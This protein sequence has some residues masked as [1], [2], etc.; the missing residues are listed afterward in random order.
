MFSRKQ[1][2]QPRNIDLNEVIANVSPMLQRLLGEHITL[3][4]PRP[5]ICPPSTPMPA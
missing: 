4:V 2:M 1:V 5:P 3:Q